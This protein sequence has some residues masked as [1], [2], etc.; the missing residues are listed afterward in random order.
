MESTPIALC[1]GGNL[2]DLTVV[3][4]RK[5]DTG[6]RMTEGDLALLRFGTIAANTTV[7]KCDSTSER[8]IQFE[9]HLR[10]V[11]HDGAYLDD[12]GMQRQLE[13]V[14]LEGMKRLSVGQHEVVE[15]GDQAL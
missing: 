4:V 6:R 9:G 5:G 7:K 2:P 13:D 8:D 10:E 1:P 12:S 14:V 15:D 11:S 3:E